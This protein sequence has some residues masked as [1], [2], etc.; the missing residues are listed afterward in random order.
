VSEPTEPSEIVRESL[1]AAAA[2]PAQ[3]R[4]LADGLDDR[5]CR[6]KPGVGKLSLAEHVWHLRDMER[7]VFGPR[8]QR[9]L[10]EDDPRLE[11]LDVEEHEDRDLEDDAESLGDVIAGFETARA[12]NVALVEGTDAEQWQRPLQHPLIGR[13]TFLDLV[14]RWGRHDSEHLRQIDILAR[15]IRER[16]LP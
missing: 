6:R 9:V 14:R 3:L 7:D 16:N 1:A 12:A 13:A 10:S 2:G 8:L 15:N 5:D 11:P 4:E